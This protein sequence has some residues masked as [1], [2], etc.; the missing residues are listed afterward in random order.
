MEEEIKKKRTI[1]FKTTI[2]KDDDSKESNEEEEEDLQRRV[3]N[4]AGSESFKVADRRE[5]KGRQCWCG[6]DGESRRSGRVGMNSKWPK[7]RAGERR[8]VS[9]PHGGKSKAFGH[10]RRLDAI[11]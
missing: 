9:N 6:T 11:R 7:R 3:A 2:S 4:D 10:Q 8:V 1:A 5:K